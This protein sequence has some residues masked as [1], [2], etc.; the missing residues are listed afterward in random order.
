MIYWFSVFNLKRLKWDNSSSVGKNTLTWRPGQLA[1]VRGL[2][3]SNWTFWPQILINFSRPFPP[4][5]SYMHCIAIALALSFSDS[6]WLEN[7]QMLHFLKIC[8][9]STSISGHSECPKINGPISEKIYIE[10]LILQGSYRSVTFVTLLFF[11]KWRLPWDMTK[12]LDKTLWL[13]PRI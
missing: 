11:F 5:Q 8:L 13:F 4:A 10:F 12:S 6:N 2:P 1:L 9:K 7:V 3:S